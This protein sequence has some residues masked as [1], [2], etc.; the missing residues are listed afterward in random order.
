MTLWQMSDRAIPRSFRMMQGFGVHTFRF[1]NAASESTFVKFHWTPSSDAVGRVERGRQDQRCRPGLPPSRPLRRD[2]ARRLPAVGARHPGLRRRVRRRVR[3]RRPRRHEDHPRGAPAGPPG[4]EDDAEPGRRQR[5]RGDRA[6]RVHDPERA[7]GHRLQQRP[8]P[9]GPQL[10]LPR[11]PAQA[12][13]Q[14]ELQPDPG[15][16]TTLPRRPLPARRAH[17][18][19]DAARPGD[20]RAQL[21]HRRRPRP[22]RGRAGRSRPYPAEVSGE[23]RRI[24]AASSPT[25]TARPGQF[26]ISQTPVEQDHIVAAYVFELGKCEVPAIR[27]RMVGNL[28]VVDESLASRVSAG[29]GMPVPP[30]SEAAAL[31]VELAPSLPWAS[32]PTPRRPSRAA[33]W[34]CSWVTVRRR[35]P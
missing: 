13:G 21:V 27:M 34:A 15:Q 1:V 31:V 23:T 17:A 25:T 24:R 33:S 30:A 11:H 19:V 20:V 4:R 5:L 14:H 2:L 26:W 7:A 9:P 35:H 29:L 16:R 22:A 28:R 32:S 18:D 3:L 10:L 12:P 6:G 8:P